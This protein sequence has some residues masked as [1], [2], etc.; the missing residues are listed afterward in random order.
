MPATVRPG[1]PRWTKLDASSTSRQIRSVGARGEEAPLHR[2]G[3]RPRGRACVRG[4]RGGGPSGLHRGQDRRS[5]ERPP[6]RCR[7]A[8]VVQAGQVSAVPATA[9]QKRRLTPSVTAPSAVAARVPS[10]SALRAPGP[11]TRTGTHTH[12]SSRTRTHNPSHTHTQPSAQPQAPQTLT[13]ARTGLR[14]HTG[15]RTRTGLHTRLGPR[16]HS[17]SRTHGP[18]QP[19][20]GHGEHIQ[21]RSH[22][23]GPSRARSLSVTRRPHIQTR[24]SRAH[25]PEPERRVAL[26]RTRE[27]HTRAGPRT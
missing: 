7:L 16:T 18:A 5:A 17:A 24:P 22:A 15:P 9:S 14:A 8:A 1:A 25:G 20:T 26:A 12:T 2:P 4:G 19:L 6:D 13:V 3:L 27:T 23:H 21:V 10:K 11:R